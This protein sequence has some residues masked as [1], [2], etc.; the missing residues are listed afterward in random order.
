MYNKM[1]FALRNT[2][3]I[4]LFIIISDTCLGQHY[5]GFAKTDLLMIK[6]NNYTE[7]DGT[8]MYDAPKQIVWGKEMNGGFEAFNFDK[9]DMVNRSFRFGLITEEDLLKIVRA[10]NENFKKVSVGQKQGFFQWLDTKNGVSLK[11][12]ST[13]MDKVF[14]VEYIIEKE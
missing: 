1:L 9:N 5:I 7:K 14:M 3:C 11:L 10:N 6:G 2:I 4:A 12:E 8:I 13:Q